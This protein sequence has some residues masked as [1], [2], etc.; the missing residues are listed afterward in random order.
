MSIHIEYTCPIIS[1][2]YSKLR[3]KEVESDWPKSYPIGNV[4]SVAP[5]KSYRMGNV[6]LT[7][8]RK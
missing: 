6:A 1:I 3:A 5:H 8:G 4:M 7:N 2:L